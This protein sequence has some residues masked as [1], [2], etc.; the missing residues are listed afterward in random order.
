MLQTAAPGQDPGETRMIRAEIARLRNMPA[1]A[2]RIESYEPPPPTPEQQKMQQLEM[3]RAEAEI[4]KIRAEA[5]EAQAKAAELN[6]KVEMEL[7]KARD[8]NNRADKTD[9]DFVEQESGTAHA[10]ELD[11]EMLKQEGTLRAK[12]MDL[13]NKASKA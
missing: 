11:K 6:A 10:R 4:E 5:A 13:Q 2:E 3:M 9:L 1:L 7:A 8:Y 12:Q